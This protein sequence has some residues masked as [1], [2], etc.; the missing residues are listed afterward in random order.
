M[1]PNI[2][3]AL[4]TSDNNIDV[5]LLEPCLAWATHYDRGVGYFSSGWFSV[6]AKGMS[7]FASRGGHARWIISPIISE[8]DKRALENGILKAEKTKDFENILKKNIVELQEKLETDTLNMLS[9]M[10]YDKI[11]EFRIAVPEEKLEDGDFHDKFGLFYD[12]SDNILSFCGSMNDSKHGFINYESIKVFPSWK[13]LMDF[14]EYDKQRFEK[15]WNDLDNNVK[16]YKLPQAIEKEIFQLRTGERPYQVQSDKAKNKWEHQEKAIAAFL[17]KGNGILEMATGTGKTRTA[18]SILNSLLDTNQID[19]GI[20]TV[21]GI[22][23]LD[24]WERE[25]L[26]HS[27]I[28]RVYKYYDIHKDLPLFL[29][30]TKDSVLLVS[31]DVEF[32]GQTFLRLEQQQKDFFQRSIIICDEI[33]G[34][35]SPAMV[36]NFSGKLKKFKYRLGLSATP[37]REYDDVG[38]QFIEDEIGEIIF[39]FKLED[40]IKKG[41]LCEFDYISLHYE[42]TEE[43]RKKKR[44]IIA[45]FSAKKSNGIAFSEDEMYRL[46]ARVNKTS[47]AK[48]PL[49][50]RF[51]KYHKNMLERCI[52]FVEDTEY[53]KMVQDILIKFLPKYHTYYGHD[54][55]RNLQKFGNCELDCLLTCKR[56][57]EGIDIKSVN[58]IILFS[59]DRARIQTIQRIGRSLRLDPS[60]KNK[61][62]TV[63]D[64]IC[65]V[66]PDNDNND[67]TNSDI[68]REEWLSELSATRR[69][70]D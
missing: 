45:S 67:K 30:N 57:S 31:R 14:I 12:D 11:I 19:G 52:I 66:N 55:R 18:I 23:L 62:A 63:L 17:Q 41:I 29:L 39:K 8:E 40:A 38:N 26:K 58:N 59:A 32:L 9:W 69:E 1:L 60:N 37:E 51:I 50:L 36:S 34:L 53:G 43:E 54:D 61:R 4:N 20:I 49:F 13:G 44:D 15:L 5:E 70:E 48:L 2:P 21:N 6:N 3:L 22:D 27:K 56:I 65:D 42:L 10:I 33:H 68:E 25:L 35:G 7:S 46:L 24:Q 47:I 16:T 64:F 28:K